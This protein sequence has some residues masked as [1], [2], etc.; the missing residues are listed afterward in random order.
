M[1]NV[2]PIAPVARGS[3]RA[4]AVPAA[5]VAEAA[6]ALRSGCGGVLLGVRVSPSA[7]RT[8]LRGV[9]GD[10]LKIS[11]CAPPEDNR[12]NQELTDALANWL[13]VSRGSVRV[14][15]GHRSRDKVVVFIGMDEPGLRQKLTGLLDVDDRRGDGRPD[16]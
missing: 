9:Y 16:G 5:P 8:A 14:E 15:T 12:A 2:A 6:P 7:R 11:V 3:R 1:T 13:E 4:P 10:R